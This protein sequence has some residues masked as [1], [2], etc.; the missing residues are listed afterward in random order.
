MK[1]YPLFK[2]HINKQLALDNLDS[3]LSSGFLNEGE[4]VQNFQEKISNFFQH[5]YTLALNSCTSALTLA[6][7]LSGVKPGDEVITTSMTCVATNMPIC[8]LGGIPV[9]ADIDK[10]T[11]N[12]SPEEVSKLITKKTKAVMCVNWAGMP[13]EL[14]TLQNICDE[15]NI[16]L[17]QDAAHSLGALYDGKH[18]CHHADFTCYSFQAIKHITCGDGGALV[19]KSADHYKKAKQLKWFG[20][21]REASKNERGE[22]KGQRWDTDITDT[23]YKFYMNNISAAIGLSQIDYFDYI[24]SSHQKNAS[25]YDKEFKNNDLIYPLLFNS[26]SNPSYWVYSVLIHPEIDR[27]KTLEKLNEAGVKA[28]TVHVPNHIYSCFKNSFKE[29]PQTEYFGDHQ[30]ALPCGWWMTDE[31]TQNVVRLFYKILNQ[32]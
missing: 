7:R 26:R 21:D 17:I 30:I 22:W 2:V 14:E 29:L 13:C 23:G 5:P 20:I 4:Q 28:A 10:S 27:D 8:N 18:V 16:K 32:T 11:G 31:D 6:L 15:N 3:V 24:I 12:I 1:T 25:I 19:C 9:W